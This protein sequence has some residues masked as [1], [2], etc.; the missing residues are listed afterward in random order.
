MA[1]PLFDQKIDAKLETVR[2]NKRER[3]R[4]VWIEKVYPRMDIEK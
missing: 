2:T 4:K 1:D 3:G